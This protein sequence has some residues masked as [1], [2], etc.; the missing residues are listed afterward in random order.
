MAIPLVCRT[1]GDTQKAGVE[2]GLAGPGQGQAWEPR[3]Q[4]GAGP[5]R[6]FECKRSGRPLRV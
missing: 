6:D 3:A 2:E 4:G 1:S 5:G